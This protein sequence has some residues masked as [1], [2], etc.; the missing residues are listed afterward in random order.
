MN[1]DDSNDDNDTLHFGDDD[2]EVKYDEYEGYSFCRDFIGNDDLKT[3]VAEL[4]DSDNDNASVH[5]RRK[6]GWR[7]M[8]LK[9]PH[10]TIVEWPELELKYVEVEAELPNFSDV[11][12]NFG[13]SC[14]DFVEVPL[15]VYERLVFATDNK[16]EV[17]CRKYSR[18][19][20]RNY[21]IPFK[22]ECIRRKPHERFGRNFKRKVVLTSSK[23]QWESLGK[24]VKVKNR[25]MSVRVVEIPVK[26]QHS[27]DFVFENG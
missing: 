25:G 2:Y 11:L 22:Y 8:C 9:Q 3:N 15:K 17:V 24:A 14:D 7:R 5:V 10:E 26:S 20:N 23:A 27:G 4:D 16:Y 21:R 1:A 6:K 12:E 13:F 18:C 19:S